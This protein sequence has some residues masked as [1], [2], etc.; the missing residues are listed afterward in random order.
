MILE[1]GGVV[2]HVIGTQKLSLHCRPTREPTVFFVPSAF[3]LVWGILLC[4]SWVLVRSISKPVNTQT[5][6]HHPLKQPGVEL[7]TKT[8][9]HLG[10]ASRP[11]SLRE[12]EG[13]QG[14]AS[15]STVVIVTLAIGVAVVAGWLVLLCCIRNDCDCMFV[16]HRS[17]ESK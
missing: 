9:R 3:L 7:P 10:C 6:C 5:V 1:S 14:P 8:T 12:V 13:L 4:D 15:F 16:V 17:S 11:P 2:S